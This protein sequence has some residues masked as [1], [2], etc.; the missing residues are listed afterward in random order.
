MYGFPGST[1]HR[2]TSADGGYRSSTLEYPIASSRRSRSRSRG[3]KEALEADAEASREETMADEVVTEVA[4]EGAK[5][6]VEAEAEELEAA[7]SPPKTA[8]QGSRLRHP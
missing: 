5:A 8:Q 6:E 1:R 7:S 4:E 3:N 2:E